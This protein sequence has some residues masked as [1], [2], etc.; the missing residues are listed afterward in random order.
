MRNTVLIK[1]HVLL[2]AQ[3]QAGLGLDAPHGHSPA[4]GQ[5]GVAGFDRAAL[6]S[7]PGHPGEGRWGSPGCE[8]QGWDNAAVEEQSWLHVNL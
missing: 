6:P 5:G 4:Q 2:V 3:G 1:P 7:P 8:P